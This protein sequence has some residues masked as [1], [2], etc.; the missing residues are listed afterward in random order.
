MSYYR[1]IQAVKWNRKI[2]HLRPHYSMSVLSSRLFQ[3]CGAAILA[4][5]DPEVLV[6]VVE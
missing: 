4:K 2:K 1:D 6:W 5:L 3:Y